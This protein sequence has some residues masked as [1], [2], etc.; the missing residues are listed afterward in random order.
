MLPHGTGKTQI[1][2]VFARD[3]QAQ[4]ARRAGADIVGAEDLVEQIS[5][6]NINFTKT[7]ATPEVMPLVGR[8]A[9]VREGKKIG[10]MA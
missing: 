2:A 7:I 5:S 8:V 6:G 1:V 4:I 9:R 3:D 10:R